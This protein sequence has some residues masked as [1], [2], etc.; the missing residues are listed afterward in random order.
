MQTVRMD[1]SVK[2]SDWVTNKDDTIDKKTLPVLPGYHIL[3]QPVTVKQKT[4]GGI[5]LPDSVKDDVAYL[6][7]VAKVLKLGDLA[8]KDEVKFPL[9]AWCEEDDY[10]C[11]G[12]FNGQKFVYKGAKLL[13]LF[14]DQVIMKVEDPAYLDTTYNL[15]N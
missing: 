5:L 3:V 11:F 7:T 13:L 2:S 8:Y 9:G 4:K 12:K 1:K 14:D 10:I 15:S 6:T